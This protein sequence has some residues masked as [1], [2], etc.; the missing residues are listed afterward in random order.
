MEAYHPDANCSSLQEH[1]FELNDR[2]ALST[3][4][5]PNANHIPS[6]SNSEPLLPKYSLIVA[7][8]PKVMRLKDSIF[9][10]NSRDVVYVLIYVLV[11]S[12]HSG[13]IVDITFLI[14]NQGL[15]FLLESA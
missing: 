3:S 6:I 15:P 4:G 7:S 10:L 5:W 13:I 11:V 9:E 14:G 12:L 8:A 1:G 2:R